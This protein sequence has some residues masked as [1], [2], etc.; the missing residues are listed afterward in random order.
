MLATE[1]IDT[2]RHGLEHSPDEIRAFI[3]GFVD[4]EIPDY[5]VSAWLM[6]VCLRDLSD[7]ETV[8]LTDSMVRSGDTLDFSSIPGIKIDKHSTGGIGDKV[9]LAVVPILAA[10]GVAVPKMSGRGL[11]YT[12]GTI[13]KL[14]S[15]P[16]YRVSLSTHEILA[17]VKSVGACI[18]S[19]TPNL[20]PA[21]AKLYALR[22]VT[23]TVESV[24]LVAASIMS[25]KIASGADAIV[26]DV[27]VGRGAF[28]KN[29]EDAS[30]LANLL[31]K[32]G[33]ANGKKVDVTL[34]SMDIPLGRAVGNWIEI[35]EVSALLRG[36][37]SDDR[38]RREIVHLAGKGLTLA[39]KGDASTAES[40]LS[41]GKAW[42]KFIEIVS[43]QGGDVTVFGEN[44]NADVVVAV[45][46]PSD[47]FVADI[48]A[49]A[50][51]KSAMRLGAGRQKKG[52]TIDPLAGII[53]AAPVG[54]HVSAGSPLAYLHTTGD[55]RVHDE[56]V[57]VTTA[58]VI[59]ASPPIPPQLFLD[60]S[61]TTNND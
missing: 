8:A 9:T 12:G 19:Q 54:S 3:T 36:L 37:P 43:A 2:K 5:Q 27:K 15:I 49:L 26:I 44:R 48:D 59:S 42:D 39:G 30:R 52:D 32:I 61:P 56:A 13:D 57:A 35:V 41:I 55:K 7:N 34:T 28:M 33:A 1:F 11:G 46:S 45:P 47:G 22:D 17:T 50:I 53:L 25:K 21:D 14:E 40:I 58:V 51:G 38:L 10:A 4:G 20:V 16:G 23:A 24:P 60:I 29:I 31:M 18:C 6:A